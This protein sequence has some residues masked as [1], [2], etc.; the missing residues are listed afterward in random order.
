LVDCW[1]PCPACMHARVEIYRHFVVV[2]DYLFL[3]FLLYS[4]AERKKQLYLRAISLV[5]RFFSLQCS[6]THGTYRR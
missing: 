6:C 5:V 3:S 1:E 2:L 4:E